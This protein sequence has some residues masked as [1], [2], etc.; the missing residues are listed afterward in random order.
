MTV[1][2][3]HRRRGG[4]LTRFQKVS[5]ATGV[6]A[7]GATALAVAVVPGQDNGSATVRTASADLSAQP[8]AWQTAQDS[9]TAQRASIDAQSSHADDRAQAEA[10]AEAQQQAQ[11]KKRAEAARAADAERARE[12]REKAAKEKAAKERAE[13][14]RARKQAASRSAERKSTTAT[15][16][17]S[18]QEIARQIIGDE[19]QF[20]CFSNIVEHES[21]WNPRAQNASS[22][23][24]GLVQ[25]LPGSKMASAGSDWRT[26]PATQIKWGLGYMNDRYGSPCGAWSFWQANNWY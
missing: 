5:A 21:G 3:S 13:R 10:K 18:P 8:V 25:A 4:R 11:A 12:A 1:P 15:P 7:V 14:E 26:N 2:T 9:P 16:S 23:A 24:Y 6:A 20:Q 22:G 19:S 17:G